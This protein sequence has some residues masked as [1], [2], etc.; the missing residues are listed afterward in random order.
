MSTVDTTKNLEARL[1]DANVDQI[2]EMLIIAKQRRTIMQ[3]ERANLGVRINAV[4]NE[5]Q[6]LAGDIRQMEAALVHHVIKKIKGEF[7][8]GRQHEHIILMHDEACILCGK[9]V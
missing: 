1:A 5:D 2:A 6:R 7:Q 3:N 4:E 8:F 9:K